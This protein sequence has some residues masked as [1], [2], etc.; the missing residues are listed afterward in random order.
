[1]PKQINSTYRHIIYNINIEEDRVLFE[2]IIKSDVVST[3]D[4]IYD[5]LI[6][7]IKI[8]NPSL[9]MS[10]ADYDLLIKKHIGE[11][12]LEK[13]GVWV[14]YPWSAKM[15]HL[16]DKEEFI[17]LRTSR[18]KYKITAQEQALLATKRIGIIGLSVGQSIALTLAMERCCGH[19]RLADFDTV[20]LSNLN[21]LRTG[22][23][24]I[25]LEKTIIAAR[26]IVEL[27]PF[28]NVE[29][30]SSGINEDNIDDFFT[31]EGRLDLLVEV[32]DGIDIKILSR[33]KAR[34]LKIPVVM[35]TNDKGMLDV[36]RFDLE[37]GRPILH[38]LAAGLEPGKI[39]SMTNE[40]KMPYVLKIVGGDNLSPRMKDSMKE[41]G[42]SISTWP[43]LASSV[44]LGGAMTTDVCR[45]IFLDQFTDSGRYYID[46]DSLISDVKEN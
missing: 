23:S 5:Q 22:I 10:G 31:K 39:K 44:V 27:D 18:N 41:I 30:Y 4:K 19:I 16:L 12:P 7:L 21:R 45:R 14:Y 24:N 9:K 26:E 11:C 20:D 36:E 32:C 46:F 8:R 28:L 6:E 29:V 17:E 2:S 43:Q 25:G 13:Y 42:R 35:D 40:E 15:V 1:M 37:P 3:Y 34:E 38:G 33:Y